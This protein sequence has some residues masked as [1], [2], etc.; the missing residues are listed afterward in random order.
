MKNYIE[1]HIWHAGCISY[2]GKRFSTIGRRTRQR[3][4]F[5][6]LCTKTNSPKRGRQKIWKKHWITTCWPVSFGSFLTFCCSVHWWIASNTN[7]ASRPKCEED[8]NDAARAQVCHKS[9][10][11]LSAYLVLIISFNLQS[12]GCY[13]AEELKKLQGL[14]TLLQQWVDSFSLSLSILPDGFL[15]P[16]PLDGVKSRDAVRQ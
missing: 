12:A 6:S 1:T 15:S 16:F 13:F 7:P 3:T 2:E 9:L 14:S 10:D 8:R 5:Y 11:M 4:V